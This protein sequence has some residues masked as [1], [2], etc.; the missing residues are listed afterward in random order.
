MCLK[1]LRQVHAMQCGWLFVDVIE[2]YGGG[3]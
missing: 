1:S 2:G 3:G